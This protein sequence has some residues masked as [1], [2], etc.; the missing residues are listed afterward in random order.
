MH[1]DARVSFSCSSFPAPYLLRQSCLTACLLLTAN[2][3]LLALK[4]VVILKRFR[5]MGGISKFRKMQRIIPWFAIF[6]T[7]TLLISGWD[8]DQTGKNQ[9]SAV[10]TPCGEIYLTGEERCLCSGDIE[11]AVLEAFSDASVHMGDCVEGSVCHDLSGDNL[12][13]DDD[14]VLAKLK[15][16]MDIGRMC[17]TDD[18]TTYVYNCVFNSIFFLF[19]SSS[20]SLCSL[21]MAV[22]P[23]AGSSKRQVILMERKLNPALRCLFL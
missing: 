13:D 2:M 17:G 4:R 16:L 9:G 3:V 20:Y 8:D 1:S 12:P 5:V 22:S 23:K 7:P 21:E 11:R 15:A 10:R 18:T 6:L 19:H 14:C